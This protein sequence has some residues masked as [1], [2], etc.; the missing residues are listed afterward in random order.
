MI[1]L[2]QLLYYFFMDDFRL[3]ELE[4]KGSFPINLNIKKFALTIIKDHFFSDILSS[5]MD[6]TEMYL[7]EI[8][9]EVIKVKRGYPIG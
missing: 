9:H 4:S 8:G 5:T 3:V 6:V 7:I 2:L 1:D